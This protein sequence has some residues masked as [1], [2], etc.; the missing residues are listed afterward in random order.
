MN[1]NSV[2]VTGRLGKEPEEFAN[3]KVASA[4]IA[5]NTR[6]K[7]PKK[8]GEWTTATTWITL[9]AFKYQVQELQRYHKGDEVLVVG[10]LKEETWEAE[11]GRK[12]SKLVVVINQI[13]GIKRAPESGESVEAEAEPDYV[14]NDDD[15]VP[16]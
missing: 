10:V 1:F 9:K 14:G 2:V 4:S 5:N 8:G 13:T 3:G 11:G 12:N 6:Y 16:F 7:D 15:S